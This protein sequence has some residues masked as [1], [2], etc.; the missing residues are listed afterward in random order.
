MKNQMKKKLLNYTRFV[1]KLMILLKSVKEF[2]ERSIELVMIAERL[3]GP[4]LPI[5]LK[6][7]IESISC[8]SK[9]MD[10]MEEEEKRSILLNELYKKRI[11]SEKRMLN[12]YMRRESEWR[13]QESKKLTE[14]NQTYIWNK[15]REE[16]E[17]NK[18]KYI[19]ASNKLYGFFC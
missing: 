4:K 12:D 3:H 14:I 19:R 7:S 15:E 11:I 6:K 2:T 1:G 10:L 9:E 18:N 8:S 17:K 13:R 5:K 16:R